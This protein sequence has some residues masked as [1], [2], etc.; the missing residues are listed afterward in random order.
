M[1]DNIFKKA[2]RRIKEIQTQA[3]SPK[4]KSKDEFPYEYVVNGGKYSFET[5]DRSAVFVL[6]PKPEPNCTIYFSDQGTSILWFP[7]KIHRNGNSIM[8]QSEHLT[9]DIPG[10]I[11][12]MTFVGGNIGWVIASDLQYLNKET[13]WQPKSYTHMQL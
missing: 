2:L 10:I 4:I 3:F 1:N 7:V 5:Y 9:C 11:F 6:P 8:G 13:I 12:K